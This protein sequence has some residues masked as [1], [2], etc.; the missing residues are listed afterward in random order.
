MRIFAIVAMGLLAA[1]SS[2]APPAEAPAESAKALTPGEYEVSGKIEML[3]STDG[4]TPATKA[5]LGDP[6]VLARACVAA[7]GTMEP[8]MFGEAGDECKAENAY[9]RNGRLNLQLSCTRD[10]APGQ[11]LQT[12][13]GS[14]TSESFVAEATTGTYFTGTGDYSMKRTLAGK[15]VG[16]CAAAT[17]KS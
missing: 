2:E 1:C 17:A 6:P 4:A 13:N 5:K 12:I 8:M 10:G 16:N 15:R 3:R 14:F 11:V 7:D 9:A